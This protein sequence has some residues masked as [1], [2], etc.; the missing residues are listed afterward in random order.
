[1]G[2]KKK[3]VDER[4]LDFGTFIREQFDVENWAAFILDVDQGKT[5]EGEEFVQLIIAIPIE[6]SK[7]DLLKKVIQ[8]SMELGYRSCLILPCYKWGKK[9][10]RIL[11]RESDSANYIA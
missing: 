2:E 9:L 3:T 5:D 6:K 8:S 7:I 1:M 10:A 11:E 4:M